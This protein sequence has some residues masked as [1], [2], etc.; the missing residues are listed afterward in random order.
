MGKQFNSGQKLI[1]GRRCGSVVT[2]VVRGFS[3]YG[4]VKNF[5]RVVCKCL[6]LNDFAVVTWFPRP[7]YPDGDQ[8]TVRIDLS[9][10]P[11]VNSIHTSDIIGLCDRTK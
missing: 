6:H 5:V 4:L 8:L 1:H 11:N 10:V 9:D 2:S 3:M 7:T